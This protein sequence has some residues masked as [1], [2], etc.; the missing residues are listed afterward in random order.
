MAVILIVEDDIFIRQVSEWTISDLGHVA[1]AADDL[2]GALDHMNGPARVDALFVDVRLHAL[3]LGGYEVA[4]QA[5]CIQPELRVLYTSGT[6]LSAD[7]SDLF[8]EGGQF[9]Q[10]PYTPEQL[11]QSMENLLH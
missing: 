10:K 7:M 6:P 4:N 3:A 11:E 9:L 2:A 8:V 1:L 5:L